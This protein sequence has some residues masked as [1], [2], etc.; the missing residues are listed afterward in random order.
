MKW[1]PIGLMI[2]FASC[3]QA[4][5]DPRKVLQ[6]AIFRGLNDSIARFPNNDSLYLQ[7]GMLLSQTNQHELA[8]EDYKKAWELAPSEVTA[9][10]YV[11]NLMLV[12]QPGQ[13]IGL[14]KEGARRWPANTEFNRRLSEVYVQTGNNVEALRQ[15]DLLLKRDSL[16]FETWVEKGNLLVRLGDTAAA[17]AALEQSYRLQ[18]INY[19]G[20]MLA[21]L[22]AATLHPK[23]IPFCDHLIAKDTA[24]TQPDL[25]FIKGIYYADTKQYKEAIA[26]FDECIR[27]DW[28]FIDAWLE[29]GIAYYEQRQY[30][31]ALEVFTRTTTVSNTNA[32]A[33]FWIGRCQEAMGNRELAIENYKKALALDK[34]FT[35]AKERI[36]KLSN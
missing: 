11:S 6:E 14:L 19:N 16:N 36:K 5:K 3:T 25:Y 9:L 29:K 20:V 1:W 8:G 26:Q 27:R 34:D 28:K 15:F 33:W 32:D 31:Q 12:N 2:V 21:N 24:G 18:P 30:E 7:R 13:A 17:I 10:L 35:Q 23:T 4:D 22:Y